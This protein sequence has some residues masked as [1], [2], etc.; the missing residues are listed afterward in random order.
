MPGRRF[1]YALSLLDQ[2]AW[3]DFEH[4]ASEFLSVDYPSLRTMASAAGDRGRDAELLTPPD[5]PKTGFQ[6]SVTKSWSTKIL[7]TAKTVQENKLGLDRLIYATSQQIG[8]AGDA[9]RE[10]LQSEYGI[11]LD[12]RDRSWFVERELK[13]TQRAVAA[14]E[15]AKRYVDPLLSGRG[16][17][18]TT[19]R[20][21]D[22]DE[23]QIALLHLALQDRDEETDRSLTKVSFDALVM[24]A[25]HDTSAEST[26]TAAEVQADVARRVPAGAPNQLEELVLGALA[27]LSKKGPVKHVKKSGVYHLAHDEALRL[28]EKSAQFLIDEEQLLAELRTI[29]RLV[30]E[31]DPTVDVEAEARLV[32]TVLEAVLLDRGEAFVQT[33]RLGTPFQL[34]PSLIHDSFFR[35]SFS[36]KLKVDQV[37][38]AVLESLNRPTTGIRQH[39]GRL[40]DAYTLFAFLQQTPDVQKVVLQIFADGDV[41]L[42]TSAVLPLLAES[43]IDDPARRQFTNI[44]QAARDSGM[45]LFVTDGV[46]EE[47]ERHLNRCYAYTMTSAGAWEGTPPFIYSS[48][49]MSGRDPREWLSWQRE[50]SGKARPTE[51][52][53]LYLHDLF[54]IT[55]KSLLEYSDPAPIDL[56]GHVQELWN[57]VHERRQNDPLIRY[58]LVAHDVENTVGIIQ[59][60][61]GSPSSPMGYTSWWLTLDR[62]AYQLGTFLKSRMGHEAPPSPVLSPDFLSQLLRLRPIRSAV[63]RELRVELPLMTDMSLVDNVPSELLA[64]AEERRQEFEGASARVQ[65]RDVRDEMDKRRQKYGPQA[66]GGARRME[67]NIKKSIQEITT[68]R[69]RAGEPEQA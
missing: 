62:T 44:M 48:Y 27:R 46:I 9:L 47:V 45:R 10:R 4:L 16:L 11:F 65:Q 57:Q 28:R 20:A 24:A 36:T 40:M 56:R 51:D 54:A 7:A 5:V 60:R 29:V 64:I 18:D 13:P 12:I 58:R 69:A 61:K 1:E 30:T 53:S 22:K 6:Y 3:L 21:L 42:D 68:T 31:E 19:P 2:G 63:E 52:V 14:E 34:D 8:P 17:L 50:I 41:W 35:R 23:G 39:L 32:R 67:A 37:V 43:L 59:L 66:V 25:L 38:A 55:T 15:L 26:K 49:V 33:V